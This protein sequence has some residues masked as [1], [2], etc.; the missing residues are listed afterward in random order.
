MFIVIHTSLWARH[1]L[2]HIECPLSPSPRIAFVTVAV[3]APRR[4]REPPQWICP[5]KN[6]HLNS[7]LVSQ[8]LLSMEPLS[9]VPS[10]I[11]NLFTKFSTL[12]SS[13]TYSM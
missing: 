5:P 6:S 1:F 7:N 9:L 3:G 2:G 12:L 13:S 10:E 11:N 4:G 8:I